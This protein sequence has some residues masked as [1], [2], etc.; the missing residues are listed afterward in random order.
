M[1]AFTTRSMA[2][3]RL[4][5]GMQKASAAPCLP[6]TRPCTVPLRPTFTSTR[7]P[8]EERSFATSHDWR[9]C[10]T[11]R[12]GIASIDEIIEAVEARIMQCSALGA[13]FFRGLNRSFISSLR[14]AHSRSRMTGASSVG[15]ARGISPAGATQAMRL[16]S[17]TASRLSLYGSMGTPGITQSRREG[18][19]CLCIVAQAFVRHP[20]RSRQ[21]VRR[22]RDDG[23][24]HRAQAEQE[25]PGV[26]HDLLPYVARPRDPALA[27]RARRPRGLG[28]QTLLV[29]PRHREVAHLKLRTDAADPPRPSQREHR[30]VQ[31]ACR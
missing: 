12:G 30:P 29:A 11:A 26:P 3:V 7:S 5:V 9:R 14:P 15:F 27:L 10:L 25:R 17:S 19:P 22:A 20:E 31:L 4:N 8:G 21:P 6:A 23:R 18:D 24:S 16:L 28:W 1:Y 2:S 13:I